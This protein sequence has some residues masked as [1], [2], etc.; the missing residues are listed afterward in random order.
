MERLN[1]L[2][3]SLLATG[4]LVLRQAIDAKDFEWAQAEI[5]L[6][7]N[8]PSLIDEPNL[9]RH[10]YFWF[11]EREHYMTWVSAPGHEKARSRM[12]TYYA[13]LWAEMEP[14]L[15]RAVAAATA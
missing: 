15:Q 4:F 12:N 11:T 14:V 7:H 3:T 10:R 5:E 9:E 6:L 2:Y 13:P 1:N 8:V